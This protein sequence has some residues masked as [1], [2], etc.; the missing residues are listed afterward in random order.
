M[1]M[2]YAYYIY[3]LNIGSQKVIDTY[4]MLNKFE[5]LKVYFLSSFS[6]FVYLYRATTRNEDTLQ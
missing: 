3:I 5:I 4:E 6:L 2:P 1:K